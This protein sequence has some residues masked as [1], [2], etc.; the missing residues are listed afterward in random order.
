MKEGRV[1]GKNKHITQGG[2]DSCRQWMNGARIFGR[3]K[4]INEGNRQH[5]IERNEK[6]LKEVWTQGRRKCIK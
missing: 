5:K 1:L 3:K 2:K 6:E 4:Q